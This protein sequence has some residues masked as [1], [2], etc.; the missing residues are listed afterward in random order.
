MIVLVATLMM[1]FA[2]SYIEQEDVILN[3]LLIVMLL[4]LTLPKLLVGKEDKSQKH[5]ATHKAAQNGYILRNGNSQYNNI[6]STLQ[7]ACNAYISKS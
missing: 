4:L 5:D 3:R 1:T 7:T 2:N 6:K